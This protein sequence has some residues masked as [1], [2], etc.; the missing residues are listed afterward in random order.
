M[1]LFYINNF[2]LWEYEVDLCFLKRKEGILS[3]NNYTVELNKT[4]FPVDP[5]FII[6]RMVIT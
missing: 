3:T 2:L 6:K 5:I 1:L 4:A